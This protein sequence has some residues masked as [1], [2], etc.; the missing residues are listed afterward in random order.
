M[1][2]IEFSKE[3]LSAGK[4]EAFSWISALEAHPSGYEHSVCTFSGAF[5]PL[6]RF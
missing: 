6:Y 1:K 4:L 2:Y 5:S 3:S